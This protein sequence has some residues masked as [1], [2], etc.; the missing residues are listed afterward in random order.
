MMDSEFNVF[1]TFYVFKRTK[2][3][4]LVISPELIKIVLLNI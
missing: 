3:Y 1:I 2:N 4:N